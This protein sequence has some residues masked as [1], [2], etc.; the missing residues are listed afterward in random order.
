MALQR[1]G[2]ARAASDWLAQRGVRSLAVDSRRVQPGD[3]FIAWPG[4]ALDGRQYVRQALAGGAVACLVEADGVEAFDFGEGAPVAALAGLKSSTGE[5]ADGFYGRPSERLQ[6]VAT[7]GTN[8]KT[9][10]AWWT[11]QA[12]S[13]LGRRCGVIGTLGVGEPSASVASTGLT[14]PDPV[15]LQQALR[16]FADDG[17][18]ACAIEASSIGIVEQR[19]AGT[20]IAVALFTNFTQD[21][22]DFHGSMASYW[23]AK[24]ALFDWPGLRAAI[25]NVDDPQG[26]AL[27]ER[28]RGLDCW[29]YSVRGPARLR[30]SDIA[31]RDGGL[32]FEVIEGD[33]RATVRSALIGEYNVSNLLAVIGGLRALG[34]PLADA[35]Q[36]CAVLTPVPGRMQ[37]VEAARRGPEVV[38][39]YAHSP[40]ALEKALE[41]LRPF[42]AQRGG[43]LWCVFGCGGNRDTAKR[44]LMGGIAQRLADRVV[45]TS[46]NPRHEPPAFILLQIVAGLAGSQE[47]VNVIEDRR[48]AIAHAV[49]E[50]GANDVVLIAGKGHEDYQE[51]AGKKLP[52]SDV[53]EARFA[54]EARA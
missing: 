49:R 43:Q 39:D 52:F 3:A 4:H 14:T 16:R 28:L 10:T 40:D 12:L 36:A 37:R 7:T 27:A 25:L 6:V 18:A 23:E 53:D 17:F 41:A 51:I 50:A 26:A 11:A 29:A 20:R 42:A 19:L 1:L 35:A 54:L 24:S 31:Y 8:G 47:R 38:V 9:S 5:I 33:Q 2:D 48:K 46:D 32:A 22:L 34:V 15:T 30:A 13:Q 21:H 45:L 44:P